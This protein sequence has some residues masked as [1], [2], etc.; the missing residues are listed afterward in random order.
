MCKYKLLHKNRN[1]V[2]RNVKTQRHSRLQASPKQIYHNNHDLSEGLV[3]S[4]L[5]Y[6]SKCPW[7]TFNTKRS[8]K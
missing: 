6:Y 5:A 4:V 3:A 7:F 8:K 1:W 2:M